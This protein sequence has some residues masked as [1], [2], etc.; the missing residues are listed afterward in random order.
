MNDPE[1][2]QLVHKAL[3]AI[4]VALIFAIPLIFIFINRLDNDTENELLKS[5]KNKETLILYITEDNCSKC[6]TIKKE[7]NNKNIEY[8]ELNKNKEIDYNKIISTL[9]LDSSN[10]YSPA[11]IYIE[12]GEVISYIVDVNSKERL[13]DYLENYK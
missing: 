7:L 6:N 13:D 4:S 9:E 2:K 3:F 1:F 12:N 11:I 5:I 8:K 10:M